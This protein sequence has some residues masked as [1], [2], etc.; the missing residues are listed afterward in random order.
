MHQLHLSP[1]SLTERESR[2]GS[3]FQ[4]LTDGA[5]IGRLARPSDA[6]KVTRQLEAVQALSARHDSGRTKRSEEV[7]RKAKLLDLCSYFE[8]DNHKRLRNQLG[9]MSGIVAAAVAT[10]PDSRKNVREISRIF[11]QL[12]DRLWTHNFREEHG[13]YSSIKSIERNWVNSHYGSSIILSSIRALRRE[14]QYFRESF[15]Q[16]AKLLRN[17]EIPRHSGQTYVKL[18]RGFQQL[19]SFKLKHMEKEEVVY[20]RALALESE[21]CRK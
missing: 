17:Y 13:L 3:N 20:S 11:L 5:R 14:H 9:T 7:G 12:R 6:S 8:N 15:R 18:V 21:L 1:F 2:S 19:E 4:L 10:Y 16:I